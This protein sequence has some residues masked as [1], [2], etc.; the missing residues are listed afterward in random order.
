MVLFEL[1]IA[2]LLAGAL[3]FVWSRRAGVPYPALL[4][5]AGAAAAV[6][7]GTP[8]IALEPELAL[9]LFV[10]PTLLDAA[11][12][13]S[14]RDMRDNWL[15]IGTLSV[16]LVGLTV[17]IVAVV[18]H[19]LV[20]SMPWA[21]CIALGAIVAPPDASAATAVLRQ[22]RPPHRLLVILEGES[23][24]N[25][26]TALLIYRVAVG[27]GAG[28]AISGWHLG[29]EL[30]LTAGGG[31]ALGWAL[32][33]FWLLLPW[34]RAEIPVAVLVQFLGTFA[35]WI[36]ADRLGV[37]A[38]ITV[39]VYAITL[40]RYVPALSGA[41]HRIA[42][43]AVWDVAVFVLN[44]LAFVL[45][46][47]QLK[48]ILGR[49]DGGWGFYAVVAV[50][51]CATVIIVRI[52]WVMAYNAVLRWKIQRF[53]SGPG[54]QLMRATF[55]GGLVV[56]WC[57]MRGIVTL[58]TALALPEGFAQRD[59][60]V[61]CA[62][63]VVLGTLA[64]QGLTLRPLLHRLRLPPDN[65]VLEETRLARQV[66]AQAAMQVLRAHAGSEPAAMLWR[67]Y[68]ARAAGGAEAPSH[69]G[70]LAGLQSHA[71][72]VQ[73]RAL[74]ALRRKGTI[75]DDAF[76]AIEEEL[77]II[78]LTADPRVR[79]LDGTEPSSSPKE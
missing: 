36:L 55:G 43:Y 63:G 9:V 50:A 68:A 15:P 24:W 20:P 62:F 31:G 61:F 78:E 72:T 51:V 28:G 40:A 30:L 65:S 4:S 2:L 70:T 42:S 6:I 34:H 52:A 23:L 18:A 26:A 1:V 14:P 74:Q 64:L 7:P 46:G 69:A 41:R 38:I 12:D 33:R 27:A 3:L 58:A 49:L 53:G 11:Y 71:V 25:D 54:R 56:S 32:A 29:P 13:A 75:G 66:T 44:V 76:H 60:I 79:T 67:E 48:G 16:V 10:A 45:I 5:L 59:L 17:A 19:A 21:A 35:V 37:S 8:E 22:L 47:L 57:G 77:D 39:V 73:R